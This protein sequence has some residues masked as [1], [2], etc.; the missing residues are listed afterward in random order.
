MNLEEAAKC[1]EPTREMLEEFFP[2]ELIGP[3]WQR[4]EDGKFI[5]PERTLGWH[6]L[7]WVRENLTNFNDDGP[8]TLTGEQSRFILWFYA[9]DE[10]NVFAYRAGVL[11]RLKGWGK[12][13]LSAVLCI[14]ELIG[15]CR[16]SH[17]SDSGIPLGKPHPNAWVGLGA[18]SLEQ[19]RNTRSLFNK[20]I[21]E[22]TREKYGMRIMSEIIT[23]RGG[24]ARLHAYGSN[25]GSVEGVRFT[26]FLLNET[27]HWNKSNRLEEVYLTVRGN[28]SK[29]PLV[30]HYLCITNAYNPGENSVA[31]QIRKAQEDVWS[32]MA[33]SDKTLYDSLEAHPAVPLNSKWA[34]LVIEQIR[35]DATWLTWLGVQAEVL[36][37][38]MAPSRKRRMWYNQIVTTEEA[39][40]TPKELD[41]AVPEGAL[42]SRKDLKP[43]DEITLGFDG[44]RTDD[45]TALVAMRLSDKMLIP[46]AIWQKPEGMDGWT[47][48]T[49]RVNSVV[50][51][52]FA[53]YDVKAFYADVN[54]WESFIN[55]WSDDYREVLTVKATGNSPI[56]LDMRG[57]GKRISANNEAFLQSI[58]D[59]ALFFNGSKTLRQHMLN[60]EARFDNSGLKFAK[61]GGRESGRKIDALVAAT[62]AF[63]AYRDMQEAKK[64]TPKKQYRGTLL[65]A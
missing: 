58:R 31:E 56:A 39:L 29:D 65:R 11:Q 20:I 46:I 55:E 18:V 36:A 51:Q 21:P 30:G 13:P 1:E 26:F 17:D 37:G 60:A 41:A 49:A 62:L 45:S 16:Y 33:E 40:F 35:G 61:A 24:K 34:P 15:P 12:D 42:G 64:A 3:T 63:M 52:T 48:D 28:V 7:A 9:L 10:S 53:L 25:A 32:G 38:D 4:D 22:R 44:G 19:T 23:A 14:V 6:I 5:L 59:G 47:I 54:L 2:A 27:Q 43:G 50:H 57:H 8:M